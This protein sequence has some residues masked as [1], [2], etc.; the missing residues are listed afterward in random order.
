MPIDKFSTFTDGIPQ[1]MRRRD[2]FMALTNLDDER[3]WVPYVDG[4]WFQACLFNVTSGGFAN[5][6]RVEPG[7]R[8]NP[9]YHVSTV[10]GYTLRGSWRY[11]EHEWVATPGSYI[12]EP[13]GEAHTLVVD[14]N[15]TEPMITFF[16]LSGGL[17]YLDKV[18]NGVVVGYDDGFSLLEL[19]RKHYRDVGLDLAL[20]DAMIR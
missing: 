10:H 13:A 5:V 7:K 17:I 12:F 9:H 11:L 18:D 3:L 20:I 1:E 14:A 8:L 2:E 6:L 15:A 16:V 19:A 4:V